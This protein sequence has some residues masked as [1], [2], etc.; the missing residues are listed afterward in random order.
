M[1]VEPAAGQR[2]DMR[3]RATLVRRGPA[4][5]NGTLVRR[6][7]LEGSRDFLG[8]VALDDVAD[9]HVVEVLDGDTAFVA[10]LH[11][12]DVVLEPAQRADG[13]VVYLDAV[14][15]DAH[16][17][18][19]RDRAVAHVASG[20]DADLRR[21]ERLTHFRLAEDDLALLGAKHAL[22]RGADVVHGIVDDLVQLDLDAF[23]LRGI[24]RVV[25]RT[26]VEADDDRAS[27]ASEQNVA[28]G[29]GTDAAV[30]DLHLNFGIRELRQCVGE[31]FRRTALIGLDEHAERPLLTGRCR[32]HEV[33]ERDRALARATALRLAVEPLA[34]LG[35][36]ARLRRIFDD[37]ELVAG[38]GHTR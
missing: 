23:A 26:H 5:L 36:L 25:V 1:I 22:E 10:L 11:L 18:L 6:L 35:D 38:H 24:A 29:D 17:R 31:R 21:L 2:R 14:A 27:R 16:A 13:T 9:L 33:L 12:T 20:D 15:D 32:R 3:D 34:A 4:R 8:A 7:G 28:L 30:N 19:P 37:A